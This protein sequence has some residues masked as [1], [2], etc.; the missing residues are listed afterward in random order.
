MVKAASENPVNQF[1]SGFSRQ[2]L[3]NHFSLYLSKRLGFDIKW[4]FG[5]HC[6]H[7]TETV[8]T[9]VGRPSKTCSASLAGCKLQREEIHNLLDWKTST[10][11]LTS[12]HL[13][14]VGISSRQ[15][16]ALLMEIPHLFGRVSH[17]A[18]AAGL[19]DESSQGFRIQTSLILTHLGAWFSMLSAITGE[20]IA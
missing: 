1:S 6:L 12:E 19:I 13:G 17:I 5:S 16:R 15:L 14:F 18:P 8:F 20:S 7:Q 2:N 3:G 11:Y 10:W 9:V 4:P